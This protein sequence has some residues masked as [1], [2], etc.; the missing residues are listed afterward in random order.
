MDAEKGKGYIVGAGPGDPE[1]ISVKGL[2]LLKAADC[3][4]YDLLSAP[5]LLDHAKNS[6]E[7][8]CVGKKDGLHLKEQSET[9]RLLLKKVSIHGV[10]VRLKGGDPFVF[11]RGAEEARYLR[12]RGVEVEVVPGITSAFAGPLSFGIPL[13]V[14]DKVQS[15]AV[16]TG[17]KKDPKAGIE[18]PGCGTLVYLMAVANI[19]N[20]VKALLESGRSDDTPCA[21]VER[22][23]R[24]DTRI[25][26]A[27]IGTIA[28]AASRANVR[29]P[30][31]LVVGEAVK[32]AE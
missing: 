25:T 9:N 31:V 26:R 29:P 2:R 13:T 15:V 11:S 14:K 3:I 6:C 30:A 17:R 22:A 18:A 4:L 20:V 16:I 24:R 27:T 10:V 7:K 28:E 32:C 1:L 23:T 5:E 12:E 19:D 21:F 8:I